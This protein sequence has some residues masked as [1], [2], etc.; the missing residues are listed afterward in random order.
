M[1]PS[2]RLALWAVLALAAGAAAAADAPELK[3]TIAFPGKAGNLDHLAV[4]AK[5]GR[6]FV[7][8]KPNNTLDVIDLTTG[9]VVR[10]IPDQGK[11][12]GVAYAAD[13]DRVYVGNGAGT[14]NAFDAAKDYAP[15]FSA[16]LPKADNVNYHPGAKRVY[17]AHGQTL[18]ALDAETGE[19]KAT[20]ALPGDAHGFHVDAAGGKAYVSLTKPSQV[21]VVDLD[22]HE[23]TA[24]FP[25]TLA[26]GN[27]PLAYDPAA[28][29]VFVGCRK[30]PVVV[31][32]DAKSGKELGGVAI[33]GDIDDLLF[34]PTR[35][36]LFAVCGAGGVAVIEKTGEK[37]AVT[38][39]IETPKGSRTATVSPSGD[40][41]YV[42]VPAQ[43]GKGPE[44]RVYAVTK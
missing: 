39:T 37:Y 29:R 8:N 20:V 28:G 16:K 30:E 2:N 32:L 38:A 4:D 26:A 13:L 33:P 11:A 21:G 25:L 44:I 6:L 3:Q 19:V 22:R 12:S 7:A 27:S 35:G 18:T 36:R 24:K 14:C 1:T 31:I 41:L 34:D 42:G 15:A 40:R 17:V 10:Q 5:G 9:K 43:G 23:V